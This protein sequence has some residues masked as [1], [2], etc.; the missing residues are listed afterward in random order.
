MKNEKILGLDVGGTNMRVGVVQ[1]NTI[2][3]LEAEPIADQHNEQGTI[4]Q[5]LNLIRKVHDDEVKAIGI[6]VPSCV[7]LKTGVIYDTTNIPSWKEVPLKQILEDAFKVPVYIN[8]DA[9]VYALGEKYF[10]KGQGT[11]D[12]I[13]LIMGT[14]VGAGVIAN[15]K[16]VCGRNCSA[17]EFGMISFKEHNY[18]Y[19]CSGSFFKNEYDIPA[20]E[21]Y[22]KAKA[23]DQDSIE[24]W[25]T[26][27]YDVAELIK[28]IMFCYDPKMIVLGGS[29]P[30]SFE[31]FKD[32]MYEG[33]KNFEF[34]KSLDN[35]VI[36]ISELDNVAVLGAASLYYDA[37]ASK[38]KAEVVA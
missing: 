16:L 12:M 11:E 2:V 4:D 29:V 13:G 37:V 20:V 33:L 22:N 19:Y 28:T 8:N 14:G 38:D 30:K 9:N 26:F 15:N 17:G 31:F 7:D 3:Q 10:G 5:L 32:S 23:G 18:E 6:G 35:L 1:N 34:Q 21:V 24:K 27:G 25:K 36:E